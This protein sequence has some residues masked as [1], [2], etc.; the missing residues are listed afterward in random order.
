M[1]GRWQ[2]QLTSSLDEKWGHKWMEQRSPEAQLERLRHQQQVRIK[3]R[4]LA[5]PLRRVAVKERTGT[6][7][8]EAGLT[9][10]LF[11]CSF[12]EDGSETHVHVNAEGKDPI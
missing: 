9:E 12:F 5:V 11:C 7:M 1:A 6:E 8:G 3:D 4:S 2:S 10:G